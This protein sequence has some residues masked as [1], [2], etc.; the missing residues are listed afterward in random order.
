MRHITLFK[1]ITLMAML[2]FAAVGVQ[3]QATWLC[4]EKFSSKKPSGWDILP[5]YSATAPSWK[6]DTGICMSENMQCMD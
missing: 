4:N 3:A 5:A 2:L 1:R 6:P